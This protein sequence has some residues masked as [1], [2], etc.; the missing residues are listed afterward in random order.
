M[1]GMQSCSISQSSNYIRSSFLSNLLWLVI[2]AKSCSTLVDLRAQFTPNME[3]SMELQASRM[4]T[5]A[6]PAGYHTQRVATGSRSLVTGSRS[7]V[8]PAS[9][10]QHL[11][12]PQVGIT[13]I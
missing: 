13:P 12:T 9:Q 5:H 8:T 1:K 10:C 7:L 6:P 2:A 4:A 11:T 3:V